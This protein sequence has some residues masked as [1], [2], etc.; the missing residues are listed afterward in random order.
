M[1]CRRLSWSCLGSVGVL[2]GPAH[3]FL[4]LAQLGR[5]GLQTSPYL[6]QLL[7]GRS[8]QVTAPVCRL[9]STFQ[10][11]Q[12][13]ECPSQASRAWKRE[14]HI[15]FES[16]AAPLRCTSSQSPLCT[17]ESVAHAGCAF[18]PAPLPVYSQSPAA[19]RCS[20][21]PYETHGAALSPAVPVKVKGS[22]YIC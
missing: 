13:P 2:L 14:V 19:D 5:R 11:E 22:P 3:L 8:H 17:I 15:C 12:K 20:S 21:P 6:L 4:Q 18:L 10:L 9:S 1:N 7:V 16:R